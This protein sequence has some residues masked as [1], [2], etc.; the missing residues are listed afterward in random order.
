MQG[1]IIILS[2]ANRI[3]EQIKPASSTNAIK[4]IFDTLFVFVIMQWLIKC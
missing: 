3:A 1:S 2:P 4:R